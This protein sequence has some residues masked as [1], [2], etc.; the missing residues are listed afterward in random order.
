MLC[1]PFLWGPAAA[2]HYS[3][4]RGAA[5][6]LTMQPESGEVLALLDGERLLKTAYHFP[7]RLRLNQTEKCEESDDYDPRFILSL[8]A[9]ILSPEYAL[10]C[11]KFTQSS[12]TSIILASLSSSC[13]EVRFRP[14]FWNSLVVIL[15]RCLSDAITWMDGS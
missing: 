9:H 11:A 1:R 14:V 10:Q 2:A 8:L 13:G 15:L 12:A 3:I 6:R 5:T 4:Q 7:I